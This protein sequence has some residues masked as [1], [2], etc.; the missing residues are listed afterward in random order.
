VK[1]AAF[2]F[3][4]S[5]RGKSKDEALDS[6]YNQAMELLERITFESDK[7]GGKPC[8]RGMRIRVSDVLGLLS[9]DL[10]S[11]QVLEE[12]PDLVKEDVLACLEY[13][14]NRLDHP[15]LMVPV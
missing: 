12:F 13:A 10:T 1:V 8:I 2:N 15:R 11:E 9:R 4:I 3:V 5:A 6:W 14:A 7:C